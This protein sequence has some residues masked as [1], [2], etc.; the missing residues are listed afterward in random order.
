MLFGSFM[1]G[2][3]RGGNSNSNSNG[4]FGNIEITHE[5]GKLKFEKTEAIFDH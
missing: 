3:D 1:D 4:Q 2:F 5:K